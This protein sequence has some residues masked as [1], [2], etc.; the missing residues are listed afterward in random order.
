MQPF[1]T[2]QPALA[3]ELRLILKAGLPVRATRCG[4]V[5]LALRGVQ[6]R[7][8]DPDDPA[9]RARALDSLLRAQLDRLE[10]TELAD[11]AVLLFG[12]EPSTSGAT[13][14]A[15]REAAANVAG[16]EA[17]HFRKRIEPKLLDLLAWQLH[18]DSEDFV[19]RRADPPELTRSTAAIHLPADV[20]AWEAAEHQQALARLWSAV[21]ALRA[22][23]LA[24]ARLV[25]MD[26]HHELDTAADL[27]LWRQALVLSAAQD[28][29]AAY[30]G[31]LLHAAT[32][33]GPA[34]VAAFAGWTPALTDEQV[35]ALASCADRQG[36]FADFTAHLSAT[37]S[38]G[39][40]ITTWRAALTGRATAG[41]EGQQP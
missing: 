30:G 38:G 40:L 27:A 3:E 33:L 9:S 39:D 6:G 41:S 2:G 32:E 17:H 23:L 29:R 8:L 4:P 31:V 21:Y 1:D 28:Y 14:T 5:L 34:E 12:A 35:H 11:A 16:F 18:R 22:E 26:A 24:V 20:F 36:G 7:A 19:S 10:N 37:T 15:R 25:S 13:L